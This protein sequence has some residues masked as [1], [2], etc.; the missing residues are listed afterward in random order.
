MG[1]GF[2]VF[3]EDLSADAGIGG[4]FEAFVEA[5]A[6]DDAGIGGG[7]AE[8]PLCAG[9]G[10]GGGGAAPA[11]LAGIGGG[12]AG[13]LLGFGRAAI[14]GLGVVGR[15]GGTALGGRGGGV[16][17]GGFGFGFS[18]S[19][20]LRPE[21]GALPVVC[22]PR[23]FGRVEMGRVDSRFLLSSLNVGVGG[24]GGTGGGGAPEADGGAGSDAWAF[25]AGA[26]VVE[27]A[28]S[29]AASTAMS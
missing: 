19:T 7:P 28:R 26:S 24:G 14:G 6:T 16:A 25:G 27:R 8:R 13:L 23:A 1:G 5:F 18:I 2:E 3:L 11:K 4:G 22:C 29:E 9:F 10:R 21:Y 15:G 20:R 17:R 12:R